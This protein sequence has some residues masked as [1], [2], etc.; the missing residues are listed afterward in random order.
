MKSKEDVGFAE[1]FRIL[2]EVVL[3]ESFDGDGAL[4]VGVDGS[5]KSLGGAC[6]TLDLGRV[7]ELTP[8]HVGCRQ[9]MEKHP[10]QFSVM[11]R[12]D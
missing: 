12:C 2:L 4:P 11:H 5:A 10:S 7:G 3:L 9:T 6:K 1:D 8:A